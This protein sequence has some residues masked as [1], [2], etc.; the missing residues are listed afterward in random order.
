[1][2][3]PIISMTSADISGLYSNIQASQGCMSLNMLFA[4]RVVLLTLL[5]CRYT[6][7]H[8]IANWV[9]N[10]HPMRKNAVFL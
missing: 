3:V 2:F 6:D 1:M 8:R 7:T 9:T 4:I 10:L 5:V